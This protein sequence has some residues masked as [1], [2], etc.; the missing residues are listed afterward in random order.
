MKHLRSGSSLSVF[1]GIPFS[2]VL[3][4][5]CNIKFIISG[6]SRR[7]GQKI[8]LIN[9]QTISIYNDCR[10]IGWKAVLSRPCRSIYNATTCL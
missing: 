3:R 1:D 5:N 7:H 9:K 2:S 4:L 10:L 6:C 8:F